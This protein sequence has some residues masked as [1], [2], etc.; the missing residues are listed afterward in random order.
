MLEFFNQ[1][2][3][4]VALAVVSDA[5]LILL[6][7]AVGF[8]TGS[9]SIISE[10]IHSS[11]D[12]LA[13]VIA[14]F[15]IRSAAKPPDESHPYGH[16]KLESLAA[17]IEALLIF[18]AA[19]LII[20]A[21]VRRLYYGAVIENLDWGIGVM[22]FSSA[23]DLVVSRHLFRVARRTESPAISAEAWN[24]T[25]DIY[26]ALAVGIGLIVV[27]VTGIKAF[28]PLIAIG[29]A[30]F[31]LR[32]GWNVARGAVADLLDESLP[33]GDQI[34]IRGVLDAH[35][36]LYSSVRTMRTRRAGG[37]RVVYI[38]LQFPP[39]ASMADAH[40]VTEHLEQEIRLVYPGSSVTVE[41]E[42]PASTETPENVIETVERVAR[43]LGAPVHHT[44]AYASDGGFSVSLH[45]EVDPALS[46]ADAHA[47][48]TRLEDALRVDIPNLTRVDSHIE[49]VSRQV[50]GDQEQVRVTAQV[51][52]ALQEL[53]EQIPHVRGV[54]DIQV[55]RNG[56]S[57]VVSLHC[58]LDGTV[59]IGDAHRIGDE[60]AGGLKRRL[61]NVGSVL[62][63]TEPQEP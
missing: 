20:Y 18:S 32:A 41:P 47:L 46:L 3:G 43:R 30:L 33:S 58:A 42:A 25:T 56:A 11:T 36:Q 45:L 28:D 10:A 27:R 6:K 4:A 19:G 7:I 54:H 23:T 38:A 26:G 53:A 57:L 15:A 31:I 29:V 5:I 2:T 50:Q 62:V 48:S 34:R 35:R 63:H 9:V 14:F 39:T 40:A 61:P 52:A 55:Q 1:R 37:R 51:H 12:L 17:T 44:S 21:G 16:G 22:A 13:A 59:P 8:Y 49:P 24:L 60:I